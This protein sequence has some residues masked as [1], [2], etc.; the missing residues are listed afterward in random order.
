MMA[1]NTDQIRVV[2]RWDIM[3]HAINELEGGV[4][5][6]LCQKST[7]TWSEQSVLTTVENERFGTDLLTK[8]Q[9]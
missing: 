9:Y 7:M 4:W 8:T 6:N 5:N 2:I 1:N 3:P